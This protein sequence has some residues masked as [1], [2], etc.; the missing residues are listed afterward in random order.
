MFFKGN[1]RNFVFYNWIVRSLISFF[2][3]NFEIIQF[4][5]I[6]GNI[7]LFYLYFFFLIIFILLIENVIEQF[8]TQIAWAVAIYF[9]I[10]S[11]RILE[12]IN[13]IGLNH[14]RILLEVLWI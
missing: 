12:E 8:A 14:G 6:L 11:Y 3:V 2:V 13:S 5:E 10:W 1:H 7:W 9:E 4:A